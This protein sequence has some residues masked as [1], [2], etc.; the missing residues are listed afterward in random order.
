MVRPARSYQTL[1]EESKDRASEARSLLVGT[2]MEPREA[3][4]PGL[5]KVPIE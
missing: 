1:C 3:R 2:C 4:R 5:W